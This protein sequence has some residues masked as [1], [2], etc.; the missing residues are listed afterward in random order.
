MN[1]IGLQLAFERR[2]Q[3]IL[4]S[5]GVSNSGTFASSCKRKDPPNR[6]VGFKMTQAEGLIPSILFHMVIIH[7]PWPSALPLWV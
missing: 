6:S 4:T 3:D 1:T 7:I 5:P 2:K